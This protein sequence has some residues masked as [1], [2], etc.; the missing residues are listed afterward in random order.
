MSNGSSMPPPL[1]GLQRHRGEVDRQAW[2]KG[3]LGEARTT[4]DLPRGHWS[5]RTE[6]AVV[7]VATKAWGEEE[8]DLGSSFSFVSYLVPLANATWPRSLF[9]MISRGSISAI[10]GK[11][12]EGGKCI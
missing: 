12:G 2:S 3:H 4:V 1:L 9:N 10:Q 6:A 8:A 7:T 11:A 5:D